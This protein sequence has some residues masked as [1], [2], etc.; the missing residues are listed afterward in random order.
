MR[1]GV[2][3]PARNALRTIEALLTTVNAQTYPCA[4]YIYD[5]CSDDGMTDF[6]LAR[7]GWYRDLV[8]GAAKVEPRRLGWPGAV[9]AAAA[10]ALEDGCDAVFIAA[11]DDLLRLDC[12]DKCVRALQRHDWVVPYSQQVGAENVVQASRPDVTL[13]DF[14]VWP[15]LTDK[16]LFRREVWEA[17]GGYPTDVTLPGSWGCKEDW[18]FWIEVFKAGFTDYGVVTEPVYYYVMHE[19]QLHREDL[20]RTEQAVALIRAKHPDVWALKE[21]RDAAAAAAGAFEGRL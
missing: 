12:V 6:L 10:L 2:A 5:D 3:V 13:A 7:P 16:A 11:A 21:Q 20:D 9:N 18:C 1:V 15:P 8:V 19:A 14:A 4:A 17:V